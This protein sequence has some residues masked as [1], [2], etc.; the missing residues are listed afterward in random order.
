VADIGSSQT[1]SFGAGVNHMVNDTRAN[2]YT[3][4]DTAQNIGAGSDDSAYE[5]YIRDGDTYQ[6][7]QMENLSDQLS[8]GS[9]DNTP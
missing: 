9:D 3:I 1:E 5:R 6:P 8:N 7:G 4:G 2:A